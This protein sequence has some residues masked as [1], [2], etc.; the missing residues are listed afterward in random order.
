VL[1]RFIVTKTESTMNTPKQTA[2]HQ[3]TWII[4]TT[5]WLCAFALMLATFTT[6]NSLAAEAV[7]TDAGPDGPA[8]TAYAPPS[9]RGPLV[10]LLSGQTGPASYQS[11][12]AEIAKLGYYA[13]LLDGKDILNKS[14]W[15]DAG[16]LRKALERG[17]RS[18][19]AQPGKAAVIG[20]SLGGGGALLHAAAMPD[21]VSMVVA[22]YP[23]TREWAD[24]TNWF[25]KRFR[26]PVLMFAAQKDRYKECCVV[27]MARSMESSAK[28]NN[29]T[30]EL[31]VYPEADHG[32]NLQTGA[33]G[34]PAGSYRA[35]DAADAWKRTVDMLKQKLP[36]K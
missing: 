20:F 23:F 25:V 32:F 35:D 34:E 1:L 9:G 8:Q 3:A 36:L 4:R 31:V 2:N 17:Q 21:Q 14:Q 11:Y 7:S 6:A 30:F 18:P 19:N 15:P 24:K 13:V 22:Y 5:S 10:V 27:E 29:A 26:V 12:A 33:H 28:S 16:N